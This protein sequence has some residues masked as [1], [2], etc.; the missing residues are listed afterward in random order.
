VR[1]L[2]LVLGLGLW[3]ASGLG[4]AERRPDVLFIMTDQHRF[5]CLGAN[6]NRLIRTPHLDALAARSANFQKAF[7][8]APVCVPS[9]A[10]WFTGRYPHSHRNRVNYT[11]L[12]RDEVMLPALLKGAGYRTASVGKLHLHPPTPDEAR[13]V[14]FEHVLL[15]DGAGRR[16]EHSDYVKWRQANDPRWEV[17]YRALAKDILAGKNPY[18]AAIAEEYSETTWVGKQSSA[19]LEDFAAG[20]DPFFLFV[21]FWRP[22]SPYEIPVPFDSLYDDVEIPLPPPKTLADV[23]RLPLPLQRQILRGSRHFETDRERLQWIYRSYYAAVSHVD[24]EVGRVLN[25]L[26]RSGRDKNTIVIFSTEH[27]D[28]LVEHGLF[29]KNV[30]FEASVRIPFL[31]S[32][33]GRI[34]PG[35]YQQLIE[36][37]DFLPTLCALVGIE[38]PYHCQGRSF[39]PLLTGIGDYQPRDVVFCENVIP[40]VI[41]TRTLDMRFV[42]HEGVGGI[43]HPD[44]KMVRSARWKLN[45]YPG[46]GGELYDLENDPGETRNLYS[47]PE[48][49]AVVASLKGRLLDWM[50]T[51]DETEQIAP[52]WRE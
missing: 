1:T 24:R 37:T 35:K 48:H 30:F 52:E 11:P 49:A 33:P 18:R 16:D 39:A 38:E 3:L 19:I 32:F 10:T 21:S 47:A 27:G 26:R 44:A 41:T 13:R 8:Q 50:I 20:E 2:L 9:R 34:K 6:G 36:T 43:R 23:E 7:V 45:Y 46:H 42:K 17:P 22:H 12:D 14:G 28:Q 5:D 4:A 40:E 25:V 51:A 31:F 15:H 29:G